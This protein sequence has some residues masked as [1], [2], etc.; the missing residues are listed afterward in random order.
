MLEVVIDI[1]EVE[2]AIEAFAKFP[3]IAR[4]A[5]EDSLIE[6]APEVLSSLK[7]HTPSASGGART[8]WGWVPVSQGNKIKF[9]NNHPA[10]RFID[11][12]TGIFR[13]GG[14]LIKPKRKKA[15]KFQSGNVTGGGVVFAKSVKGTKPANIIEKAINP[16]E[17][18]SKLGIIISQHLNRRLANL[19]FKS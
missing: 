2:H 13:S 19:L 4:S 18:Q 5:V 3:D 1:S 16:P 12:G 6:I 9:E 10:I 14:S 11:E 17:I 8:A 7:E 15:M